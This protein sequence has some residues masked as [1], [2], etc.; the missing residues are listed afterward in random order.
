MQPILAYVLACIY[1]C[2][3]MRRLELRRFSCNISSNV[4]NTS[5]RLYGHSYVSRSL[6]DWLH[7][8]WL[9]LWLWLSFVL[10]YICSNSDVHFGILY[11]LSLLDFSGGENESCVPMLPKHIYPCYVNSNVVIVMLRYITRR[12]GKKK[13][14]Q[15]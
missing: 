7:Q 6:C 4:S 2:N 3:T 5:L 13:H 12:S 8:P 1:D 15:T 10:I 11:F 9:W 14:D